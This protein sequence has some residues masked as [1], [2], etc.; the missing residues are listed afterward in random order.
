MSYPSARDLSVKFESLLKGSVC[1]FAERPVQQGDLVVLHDEAFVS[2]DNPAAFRFKV[3]DRGNSLL[4]GVVAD[5]TDGQLL[6]Y[7]AGVIAL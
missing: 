4:Y 3:L 2:E 6:D 5:Y 1:T 7:R